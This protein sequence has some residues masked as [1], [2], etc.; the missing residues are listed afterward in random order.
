MLNSLPIIGMLVVLDSLLVIWPGRQARPLTQSKREKLLLLYVQRLPSVHLQDF[1][2]KSGANWY[3]FYRI[4][5]WLHVH[6][7]PTMR[8]SNGFSVY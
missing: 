5:M 4:Q 6:V 1:H 3:D 8:I 2:L 7:P